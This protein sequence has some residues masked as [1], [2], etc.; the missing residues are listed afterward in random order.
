MTLSNKLKKTIYKLAV[1]NG[2]PYMKLD[3][4][5]Y[6]AVLKEA[7]RRIFQSKKPY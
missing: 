2:Y 3:F 6:S 4:N 1:K 5:T 7:H